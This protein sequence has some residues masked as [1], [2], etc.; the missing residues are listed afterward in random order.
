MSQDI[1]QMMIRRQELPYLDD[2]INSFY[3]TSRE[4]LY[5]GIVHNMRVPRPAS[6]INIVER[7]FAENPVPLK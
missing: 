5:N 1:Q 6:D 3:K 7:Y 4:D 2:N